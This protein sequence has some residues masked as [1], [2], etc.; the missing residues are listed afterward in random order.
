MNSD[1]CIIFDMDGVL[2]NSEPLHFEFESILFK[3]LGIIVSEK[4]WH[5]FVG[6]NSRTMWTIVKNTFNLP[7]TISEL[8]EAEHQGFLRFLKIQNP[9]TVING[10]NGLLTRLKLNGYKMALASSSPREQI[11]FILDSCNINEYFPV[12]ISGDDV[13]KG[14]P[15]PEIFLKTA[16][17]TGVKPENCL[18]IEDSSNG[19]NAAIQAGM[20]CIGYKNPD[21][22][23]QNLTS[24]DLIIDSFD[25]LTVT[26]VEKLF[27]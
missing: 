12:S 16:E 17:L 10:V 18:V 21:S 1:K 2:I 6:T 13:V 20:K 15:D 3:S 26:S 4:L 24:A 9:L 27:V 11:S 14:K 7:Q 8:L 25:R 22:G 19:V 5:S 23:N